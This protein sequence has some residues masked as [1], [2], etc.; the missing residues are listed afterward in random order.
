ML[1]GLTLL[2]AASGLTTTAR[3]FEVT[4][5]WSRTA[6]DGNTGSLGDPITVTWGLVADGTTISGSEGS[7]GS[8]LIS[9]L[10]TQIGGDP[11]ESDLTLRPWFFIFDDAFSR[12]EEVSGVSYDY[13]SNN[14][15]QAINFTANPRGRLGVRPDVRIGG[16]SIDGQSGSN[17]LAYN[18][19]PD[20]SDMV[21]DTDNTSFY[22][23]STNSYR[24]F[25]NVVM[26]EASHGLGISH[27]ESNNAVF[28][29][30]PSISTSFDGPQLDDIL[31]LQRN[32]GDALEK[33]GGNGTFGTATIL[34]SVAG[35]GM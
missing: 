6:T 7:S 2:T 24:A 23:N 21:I 32:Y 29:M 8:D 12:L 14:S 1:A 17:T 13:E 34:G 30:E 35:G 9:F 22:S 11:N 33:N 19:F 3:S 5:R 31:A 4:D 20:H 26:H 28:L 16:H 15:S 18:Y 25:R 27:M 10:D